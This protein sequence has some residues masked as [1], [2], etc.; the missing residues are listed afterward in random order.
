MVT[1]ENSF[2]EKLTANI[3]VVENM[4]SYEDDPVFIK[5]EEEALKALQEAPLPEH[6]AKLIQKD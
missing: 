6:I 2:L 1:K 4:P 5:K 3:R